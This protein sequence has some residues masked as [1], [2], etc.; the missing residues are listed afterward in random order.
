V[1]AL[2][3]IDALLMTA[4]YLQVRPGWRRSGP[5]LPDAYLL[6]LLI[7]AGGAT[8]LIAFDPST[9]L[10]V[11]AIMAWIALATGAAGATIYCLHSAQMYQSLFIGFVAECDTGPVERASTYAGLGVS[12]LACLLFLYLVFSTDAIAGLLGIGS[13]ASDFDLLQAR[14]LL[15]SGAEAWFAPG[16]FKQFRDILLPILLAATLLQQRANRKPAWFWLVLPIA[17]AAILVSGQRLVL[18]V[19]LL[20]LAV[21]G[22]YARAARRWPS[23]PAAG[24]RMP[25]MPLSVVVACYG[26]LTYLLGRIRDDVSG[27]AA[28]FSVIGNFLDRIFL[29]APRENAMTFEFWSDAGPSA[30]LSWM[31]DMAGMLPGVD[32]SLSNQLHMA[33]GG[34]AAGN[35]P[36]GLP[37]DVWLAWGWT[38][39]L[40]VPAVIAV[41]VGFLD[42]ACAQRR[43]TILVALRIYL[44]LILPVCYSPFLFLL[45]GGVVAAALLLLVLILRPGRQS[46][47]IA[48]VSVSNS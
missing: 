36:L 30:G 46:A 48:S 16:Y 12:A 37:P 9:N 13:L 8:W 39:L 7:Y 34:S 41:L 42:L 23:V 40:V 3:A 6:G 43:S 47:D 19:F 5:F 15:A 38:G 33:T 44:F 10:A 31:R 26:A 32:V 17:L 24:I 11:V 28:A 35:S 22:H 21:A 25:I 2:L 1:L 18:V 29:A 4:I 20:T 45:Y 14:V 27:V